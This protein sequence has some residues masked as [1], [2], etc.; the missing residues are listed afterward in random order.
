MRLDKD[1]QSGLTAER[2]FPGLRP[3]GYGD[4][5]FFFGREDQIFSLYR[6]LDLSRFIAV[7]GSSGSGKSS[8]VR[9]GLL[10][11]TDQE[12]QEAGGRDWR[13]IT[14]HPGD[15]P[16]S[17]LAN[18]LAG[19]IPSDEGGE[20]A[21]IEIRRDRINH[22]LR[23]SSFGLSDA[24]DEIPEV[25]G[26]ALLIVVD[27][28]EELFRFASNT[29][30]RVGD[31]LW[32]D[33]SANFVQ[34]LL[35]VSRDR[36]RS[37]H[38][39]ITMR[40]DFI[41][42]CAQFHGLPEA[43]SGAQFL[44]PS[45]TRDQREDVIR[46]PIEKAGATIE[47]PLVERLLN[48][49]SSEL[50]QLPV[51]QHCLLRLWDQAG[52]DAKPGEPRNLTL[53]DY[54]KVGRIS[55][56]L[57]QHADEVMAS[58]PGL[59]LAV[60][61]VFR[62]LSEVDKEGRA[63]RRALFF[64]Q[65][66][67]ETGIGEEQLRKV[68]DRFRAGDCSF[69]LPSP[70]TDPRL[71]EDTRIDVVHEALLRRWDRISAET[72]E[73]RDGQVETGWLAAEERDGRFYRALLALVE[74][75]PAAGAVTLPLDQ[76]DARWKWW[77]ARPR[78][79]A[80]AERYG[81]GLPRVEKLFA[82][83]RAALE[84]DRRRQVE[85][86]QRERDEERQKIEAAEAA[87]RAELEHQAEMAAIQAEAAKRLTAR[88]R[89]AAIAMGA[90]TLV[91]I[92]LGLLSISFGYQANR[93][94]S[95]ALVALAAAD[96]A[97]RL[98]DTEKARAELNLSRLQ[99]MTKT[100]DRERLR[101]IAQQ[102]IAEKQSAAAVAA[103]FDAQQQRA[104]AESERQVAVAQRKIAETQS[105]EAIRQ[106]AAVFQQAGR[107]AFFNGDNDAA[108]VYFA[109]AYADKPKDPALKLVLREALDK[110]SIRGGSIHAPGSAHAH[111][112]L[113]TTA[114]FSPN[115]KSRQIATAGADGT[116]KLWDTSG[117]LLH[118]FTD[119]SGVITALAFDPTGR[120]LATTG[121]DG[122]VKIRDL[123][124]IA[125]KTAAKPLELE[126][127]TRRIN[128]VLFNHD[129][130]RLATASGDGNVRL[131][132]SS[133]GKLL[134]QLHVPNVAY[135]VNDVAFTPDDKLVV[136][137][138]SDGALRVW[139]AA[140]GALVWDSSANQAPADK[141]ATL[142]HIEVAPDGKSAV[143]GAVDGTVVAYDL[144]KKKR[145]WL[146]RDDRG[147][148][149]AVAFDPSGKMLLTGSDDGTARL[150]DAQ[151][152]DPKA[153][154]S[155]STAA[156]AAGNQPGVVSAL[157]SPSSNCIATTYSDGSV[158]FW[159]LN[160][161]AIAELRARG[162]NAGA[163]DFSP[164]GSLFITGARDGDLFVWHPPSTL[165][166]A[167]AAQ[168]GSIDSITVDGQG[169]ILT[170]SRDGSAALWRLGPLGAT[171]TRARVLRHSTSDW[172]VAA[173]FSHDGKKI[174]TAGG[175][176]VK[177]WSVAAPSGAPP[178]SSISAG[179]GKTP[180]RFSDATFAGDR[181]D[182]VI[183]AETNADTNDFGD[184]AGRWFMMSADGKR[185]LSKEPLLANDPAG[186]AEIRTLFS[187]RDARY[188][189]AVSG[190]GTAVLTSVA[191]NQR[192]D[193]DDP[194]VA[195]AA[196]A[197]QRD[198]YALGGVDGSVNL[199]SAAGNH[200]SLGA[201]QGRI[202]ALAFSS[203]DRWLGSSGSGD[204]VGMIW[205]LQSNRLQSTLRGHKNEITS[206]AFSPGVESFVLTTSLDG[207]AKLWDRD[208]GD[209]LASVSVP[210]SLVRSAAFTANGSAVVIGSANGS[211][212]LWRIRDDVPAPDQT[213]K[214]LVAALK[215]GEVQNGSADL[216][217]SQAVQRLNVASKGGTQ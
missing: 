146:R 67:A 73:L 187:G 111:S 89:I 160:G 97:K 184:E 95:E 179:G 193:W 201:Q 108:A 37:V 54:Q 3:F 56:A 180:Q 4:R 131:W 57:S 139:D 32:R 138:A 186:Q 152:G 85:Q 142:V 156:G 190:L 147:A 6:L 49:V 163:A 178:L 140:T 36:S 88:T 93:A 16:L 64:S 125:P 217:L 43:V 164:D 171:L 21:D 1:V 210:G 191:K 168:A 20:D 181:S 28:F 211:V 42:D 30:D 133:T 134:E 198:L 207:S 62:A 77:K 151:T 157:F 114:K 70:A 15:A 115:A 192:I 22:A 172:V 27:Q 150:Y 153:V 208:T 169:D 112:A 206:L 72:H 33:E 38:V 175:T 161:D 14:M 9:A 81:G 158:S 148:I 41:G 55:G 214:D 205:D 202:S 61:Q 110:L 10:P 78:T 98:A 23:R 209:L 159:T 66:L 135:Q 145:L 143:A 18:A 199:R 19:L 127:H 39:L 82:D 105:A 53:D 213:A 120:Y 121:A 195:T 92:V 141:V 170:A 182:A 79:A 96:K 176:A 103:A 116:A 149:N 86:Q 117:N 5:D 17:E 154:L 166:R 167:D 124:G 197:H 87:K 104:A 60:E 174:V 137:A 48:D 12:A 68:L 102:K 128:D 7:I 109:A 106:R 11:L 8:L 63:T 46:K 94:K 90:I 122:S 129:G 101:A 144:T 31:S 99:T 132:Q 204:L 123:R 13:S 26:K 162:G 215:R 44:A 83:S 126:G 100:A 71:R 136:A 84:A 183:V 194:P 50:D 196:S 212:Y 51:L 155:R 75:A 2:P 40:S 185:A 52:K 189:L 69:I 35:E 177:V 25:K 76:V 118:T 130:T 34:L 59:E 203:D 58:L 29:R 47:A 24:L 65:L 91:T 200:V 119:Q 80:W 74:A 216:L 45:L 107:D 173:S 188:V 165:V 113:I